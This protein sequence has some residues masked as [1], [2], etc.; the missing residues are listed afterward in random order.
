MSRYLSEARHYARQI[1]HYY[2][3]GGA[4]GYTASFSFFQELGALMQRADRSKRG[5]SDV[6]L[7]HAIYKKMTGLME[8]MEIRS[9]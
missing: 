5:K 7:I 8:K 3:H 1:Q 6:P 2:E 9:G 4:K